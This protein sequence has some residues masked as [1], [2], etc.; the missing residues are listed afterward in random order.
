MEPRVSKHL[1]II[2]QPIVYLWRLYSNNV[3]AMPM[4]VRKNTRK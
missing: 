3:I 2:L 4:L 1:R